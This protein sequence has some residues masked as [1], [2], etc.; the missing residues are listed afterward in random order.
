MYKIPDRNKPRGCYK[1]ELVV[2]KKELREFL[3]KY[4]EHKGLT[5]LEFNS[6]VRQFNQNIIET[7]IEN[8]DG[9]LLPERIGQLQIVSYKASK[10]R[11]VN[12]GLTNKTGTPHYEGNWETDNRIGKIVFQKPGQKIEHG[13]LWGLITARPFKQK[14]SKA[15]LKFWPKYLFVNHHS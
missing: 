4:P 10:K 5:Q 1:A 14:V 9:V 13:R 11:I 6:I 12:F 2:T 8:R 3:R 7:V 15:F